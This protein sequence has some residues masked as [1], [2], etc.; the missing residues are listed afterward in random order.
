MA[1]DYDKLLALKI[2]DIER[3]YSE[4]DAI[5]YAL[6]LGLSQ[7]PMN[8]DELAFTYEDNLKV[9]P[10]FP[11][12]VAQP[13]F[14]AREL[15]T[16]IDW[17]KVV[18]GEHDLVLHK[19]LPPSGTVQ[20]QTR[21]TEVIDKGSG[22]GALVISERT[23]TDKATG[24]LYATITQNTFCRGDGGF[25]GPPRQAPEPHV[26]PTRTPDVVCDLET[27]PEMALIY[28][29]NADMNP[30]HA[31]PAIAKAAGFPRP[32]LHGLA[33]YGVAGHAILREMCG[34]DPARFKSMA[35]RFSAPVYPGET[36]RT[37][38]WR[39]GGV[40]SYRARVVERDVI[41]LNNGRVEI[42]G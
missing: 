28:R 1:I 7:D 33:T 38:M 39:D 18:H 24:E 21:V 4:R 40:V 37:E 6:S 23:V 29:W 2:P 8:A 11:V 16:G 25:G 13:G 3:T 10:T 32:I 20:S 22:K 42:I 15:D 14:W 34:Y 26:L 12:V 19:P 9:L 36:I 31:D 27:R 17:V 35:V 5:F 30:L 41:V